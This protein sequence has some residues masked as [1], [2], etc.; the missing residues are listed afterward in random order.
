LISHGRLIPLRFTLT[1]DYSQALTTRVSVGSKYGSKPL[2]LGWEIAFTAEG[3]KYYVNH[4]SKQTMWE[5]P[6][7][8]DNIQLAIP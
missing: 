7:D 3:E 2:P 8:L 1:K 5:L 4:I 6:N